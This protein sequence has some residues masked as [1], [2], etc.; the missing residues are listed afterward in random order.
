MLLYCK[1]LEPAG[2]KLAGPYFVAEPFTNASKFVESIFIAIVVEST[3][4]I[5]RDISLISCMPQ[6]LGIW[7]R[8]NCPGR[9]VLAPVDGTVNVTII[10]NDCVIAVIS[11]VLGVCMTPGKN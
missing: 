7:N 5:S 2:L 8:T 10:G 4:N 6:F 9:Y 3:A 11:N 1:F